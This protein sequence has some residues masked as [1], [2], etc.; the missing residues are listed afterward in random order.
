MRA[1]QIRTGGAWVG[2]R[3]IVEEH[4]E[5]DPL[6]LE[7]AF[8][9]AVDGALTRERLVYVDDFDRLKNALE[10]CGAY[11][12]AGWIE[13]PAKALVE[14]CVREDRRL[15]VA[16]GPSSCGALR[17]N[18]FPVGFQE[19][20][21]EDYA[22]LL[23]AF[24]GSERGASL[25]AAK[26]HRFAPNLDAHDLELACSW[27]HYESPLSTDRFVD[28][29]RTQ[30]LASNV[31]LSQV[32]DVSLRDLQ[33]V[34]DVI[35]ALE[36]NV[37]VAFEN[38]E[39]ARKLD[40]KPK[41][42]VLLLGPPG[43]GKT[44]V[45]RALAHRLG[46]KFFMLDGT[47]IAG[48]NNFYAVLHEIVQAAKQNAPSVLFIDDGDVLFSSQKDR[49]FYRYLLTLLDGI[50]SASAE[51]V[52]VMMTAMD[53]QHLPPAL[54]RSGRIELWL[55][56]KLPDGEARRR[57]LEERLAPLPD[58]LREVDLPRVVQATESFTGADL[59][60]LVEDVKA[61]YAYDLSRQ[62]PAQAALAYFERAIGK[63]VE[64]RQR[65]AD[66]ESVRPD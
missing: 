32:G 24:L 29:L 57:I 14:R 6:E 51:R 5:R 4:G 9:R 26:I 39:L 12:R 18:A 49:G 40:L 1:A 21:A 27:L 17:S 19:F 65:F 10:G 42:G 46:G 55:Q 35:E 52:C 45:G 53:T 36:A 47:V 31:N 54:I 63:L 44:T 7:E 50:E 59:K 11:P 8:Y 56:M 48:S 37:V 28:Y 38:D 60:R 43:T 62:K 2:C 66:Q 23:R 22:T 41:R 61:L 33:G 20:T 58:D 16:T 3:E 15:V 34:D 30:K 25:D 13:V 64:N